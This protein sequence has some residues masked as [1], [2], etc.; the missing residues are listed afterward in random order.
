MTTMTRRSLLMAGAAGG[1]ALAGL[2]PSGPAHAA[3]TKN[4]LLAGQHGN[5]T[6]VTPTGALNMYYHPRWA[7]GLATVTGPFHRGDGFDAFGWMAS[8]GV[9]SDNL[10]IAVNGS[11][12]YGYYWKN[13]VG[14]WANGGS[15]VNVADPNGA[16][17]ANLAN[18]ISGGWTWNSSGT[19]GSLF[20]TIDG[21]GLLYWHLYIGVPGEGGYWAPN[22]GG[23][24]GS[25]WNS[26]RRVTA[27]PNGV[28]YGIDSSGVIRWYRY[29]WPTFGGYQ[30]WHPGSSAIV[31]SGWFGG[32]Y[33]YQTV[34][35]TGASSIAGWTGGLY[36]VDKNGNLRWNRHIGWYDGSPSWAYPTGGGAVIGT[37]WM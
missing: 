28:L 4:L 14:R 16:G 17:W 29:N 31:G 27:S 21:A 35:S 34:Q 6:L 10:Y 11:G 7:E 30:D 18:L 12:V 2:A 5:L 9:G 8:V 20:Y 23:W 26:F 3:Q 19:P 13:D 33:G 37:G 22:S 25:G 15:R 1:V 24:I 36:M 32:T